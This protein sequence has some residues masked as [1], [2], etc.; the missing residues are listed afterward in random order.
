[1]DEDHIDNE[2]KTNTLN[3][4]EIEKLRSLLTSIEKSIGSCSFVHSGNYNLSKAL[5]A[6][7]NCKTH[8]MWDVDLSAIDHMTNS[9]HYFTTYT[10]CLGNQKIKVAHGTLAS[11]TRK[12]TIPVSSS[13]SLK[14]VLQVLKCSINL[15]S[16]HKLT[17][18]LNCKVIFFSDHRVFR[19]WLWERRL[20]LLRRRKNFIS[21]ILV[22]VEMEID[23]LYLIYLKGSHKINFGLFFSIIVYD[24][25]HF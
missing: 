7:K 24:I 23:Y 20:D 18:D 6:S 2:P 9:S 5:S 1:M 19:K 10:P 21:W 11:I 16:I 17:K 14:S 12:V 13:L 25:H 3:K 22:M 8:D 15:L 4:E